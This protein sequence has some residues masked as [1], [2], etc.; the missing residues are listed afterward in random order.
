MAESYGGM[1]DMPHGVACS[2]FLPYV[3]EFNMNADPGKH[4]R[5]GEVLGLEMRDLSPDEGAQKTLE[6]ILEWERDLGIPHLKDIPGV[7]PQDFD[8][9][10]QGAMENLAAGSQPQ[11]T[12]QADYKKMFDE[13]YK[14]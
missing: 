6:H 2:I 13:A 4:A 7:N 8:Q 9:A 1:V 12:T 5:V 3:F 14:A 10:A 11:P